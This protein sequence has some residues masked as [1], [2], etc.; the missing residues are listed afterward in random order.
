MQTE[1]N[2]L[3]KSMTQFIKESSERAVR[4]ET[5]QDHINQALLKMTDAVDTTLKSNNELAAKMAS[6]E[7][8]AL[9]KVCLVEESL[10]VLKELQKETS[11]KVCV[12]E[13][14]QAREE[15]RIEAKNSV[16]TFVS[17]N[18][19]KVVLIAIMAIPT[20]SVVYDLIHKVPTKIVRNK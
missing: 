20:V 16:T 11:S 19:F 3:T 8:T 14:A 6:L 5:T 17:N 1:I 9:D 13:I 18:W 4:L 7:I 15:G 10:N 12:L 2:S